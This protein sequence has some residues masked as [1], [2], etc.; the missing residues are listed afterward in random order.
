MPLTNL[1]VVDADLRQEL[2]CMLNV[3]RHTHTVHGQWEHGYTLGLR[4][5]CERIQFARQIEQR[6]EEFR[7]MER[8]RQRKYIGDK[9]ARA[10]REERRGQRHLERLA[11]AGL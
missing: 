5:M 10:A 11:E 2:A 7:Q 8:E 4:L 9:A 1:K 6:R 3:S